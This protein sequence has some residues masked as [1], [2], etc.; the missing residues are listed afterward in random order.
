MI[1]EAELSA[2]ANMQHISGDD[3]ERVGSVME[4][5][6]APTEV[7]SSLL[8]RLSLMCAVSDPARSYGMMR[9][10]FEIDPG[11]PSRVNGLSRPDYVYAA[12][13]E[14]ALEVC[15]VC[16]SGGAIPHFNAFSYRMNNFAAP[17]SP[18][19]LWMRC[20]EC[21]NLYTYGIPKSS[22]QFTVSGVELIEPEE[23]VYMT[24][25]APAIPLASWGNILTSIQRYTEGRALLEIGIG[26]Y[27]LLA[28]AL[29]MGYDAQAVEISAAQCRDCTNT[30]GI[31]V[32]HCDMLNFAVGN[33]YDVIT[34]GD[35]VEHVTDPVAALEKAYELLCEGGVLWL[36][37]PNFESSWSRMMKWN[38]AMWCEP[39]HITW[40]SRDTLCALLERI[41]FTIREYAVSSHY[42]G[43][44]EILAQKRG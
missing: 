39:S 34:M 37:T 4:D 22:L 7:K 42:N 43:S 16:K 19:K 1:C 28:V 11:L 10:A 5:S 9:R 40:F 44:M 29:E 3:A 35:V 6:G 24:A 8:L 13:E 32:W 17:Y 26:A 31:P 21:G 15:P 2:A 20:E 41:G 38:D 18:A 27:G 23:G 36:S 25:P 14:A 33:K 30:L 12:G